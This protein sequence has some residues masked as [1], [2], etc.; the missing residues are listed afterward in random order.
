[1]A[2]LLDLLAQT[3]EASQA[4]AQAEAN[5]LLAAFLKLQAERIANGVTSAVTA[6]RDAWRGDLQVF[7]PA[8]GRVSDEAMRRANEMAALAMTGGAAGVSRG[9]S[10]VG[11]GPVRKLPADEASRMARAREMGFDTDQTFY[12]GSGADIAAFDPKRAG[13]ATQYTDS[14]GARAVFL[15]DRPAVADSYVPGSYHT[16][17]TEGAV[18]VGPGLQ[19]SYAEGANVTPAYVRGLDDFDVWD[20]GGGNYRGD[21]L[22]RAIADARKAKAP[23]VIFENM[24]DAGP[25]KAGSP[26]GNEHAPSTI[27]AVLDPSRIRSRAA[28]FDPKKM[29]KSDLLASLAAAGLLTPG[30]VAN[31]GM[32]SMPRQDDR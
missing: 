3:S 12:H 17:A 6:P 27:L 15:T 13:T 31:L 23:G 21:F 28:E 5:P 24:K 14:K 20:M 22:E 30:A 2:G 11:S 26:I 10:V 29:K 8:T 9:G 32:G 7:D 16:A 25:Y 18:D 4:Q 1:M 19:R